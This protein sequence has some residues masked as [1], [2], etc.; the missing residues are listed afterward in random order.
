MVKTE[1]EIGALFLSGMVC[2]GCAA[3]CGGFR[4]GDEG[5]FVCRRHATQKAH[6]QECLCYRRSKASQI[7]TETAKSIELEMES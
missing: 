4:S 6:R 2:F 5:C 3:C 1:R 7:D